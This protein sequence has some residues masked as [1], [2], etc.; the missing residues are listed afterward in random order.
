M[1]LF[2]SLLAKVGQLVTKGHKICSVS[3]VVS[4]MNEGCQRFAFMTH[5]LRKEKK[6]RNV[7]SNSVM[8]FCPSFIHDCSNITILVYLS[9]CVTRWS[10]LSKPVIDCWFNLAQVGV[11]I[12]GIPPICVAAFSPAVSSDRFPLTALASYLVYYWKKTDLSYWSFSHQ[13]SVI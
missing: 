10:V 12:W 2:A 5:A 1:I 6:K 11:T 4:L 9:I 3:D 13:V 8:T 7:F